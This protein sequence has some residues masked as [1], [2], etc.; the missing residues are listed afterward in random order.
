MQKWKW[1]KPKLWQVWSSEVPWCVVVQQNQL[2]SLNFLGLNHSFYRKIG[3]LLAQIW[4]VNCIQSF[5]TLKEV[6][7]VE[8]VEETHMFF[9]F[10]FLNKCILEKKHLC[11]MCHVVASWPSLP[12]TNV[13]NQ[14]KSLLATAA[15]MVLVSEDV[16]V[17]NIGKK[18]FFK[19]PKYLKFNV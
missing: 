10:N 7:L 12:M 13:K 3:C 5:T 18:T 17:W 1:C 14:L 11:L 15:T 19:F 2:N 8:I 4:L 9:N 6:L 16:E